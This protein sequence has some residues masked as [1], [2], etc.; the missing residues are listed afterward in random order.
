MYCGLWIVVGCVARLIDCEIAM[1]G[2][3]LGERVGDPVGER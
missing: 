3:R 1:D 2:G